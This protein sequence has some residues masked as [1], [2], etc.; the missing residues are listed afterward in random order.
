M[1]VEGWQRFALH[2][3]RSPG[4]FSFCEVGRQQLNLHRSKKKV[5][6][7]GA[8]S[9]NGAATLGGEASDAITS[10]GGLTTSVSV[11]PQWATQVMCTSTMAFE[12]NALTEKQDSMEW[13]CVFWL[14]ALLATK[15]TQNAKDDID[16][17]S[18]K[19]DLVPALSLIKLW[20]PRSQ[21]R[22][23]TMVWNCC[24]RNSAKCAR[25]EKA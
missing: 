24:G 5:V 3:H 16:N 18:I 20:A 8:T 1:K 9:P 4:G 22:R 14:S 25:H 6:V 19:Q 17:W 10:T 11:S 21:N 23:Q 13:T 2:P 15:W 12:S 7:K